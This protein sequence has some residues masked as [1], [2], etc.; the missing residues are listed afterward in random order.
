MSPMYLLQIVC[1]AGDHEQ[2]AEELLA[3]E[4]IFAEAFTPLGVGRAEV[5]AL[6]L[7]ILVTVLDPTYRLGG[8]VQ[9]L[10]ASPL[11][12]DLHNLLLP[13]YKSGVHTFGVLT[14]APFRC[15]Y[16]QQVPRIR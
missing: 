1:R 16:H 15:A 8:Y 10:S 3:L 4:A 6:P 9:Y 13:D 11:P 5:G 2:Q 7:F 12:M 14:A